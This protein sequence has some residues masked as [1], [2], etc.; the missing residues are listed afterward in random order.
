MLKHAQWKLLAA[1]LS[2]FVIAI[3]LPANADAAGIEWTTTIEEQF[4]KTTKAA[5]SKTA[6]SLTSASSSFKKLLAQDDR[7]TGDIK[8]L[9][10]HNEE[11]LLA[12]KK[13]IKE[14]NANKLAQLDQQVQ[15]TRR[16]YQPLL[17]SYTA[18]NKQITA[19]KSLK[20]KTLTSYLQVQAKVLKPLT[21][22]ARE[23]IK[24]KEA[25]LKALKADTTKQ[26]KIIRDTLSRID[27]VKVQIRAQRS[28]MSQIRKSLSPNW[29]N[30]KAAAKKSDP[31]SALTSLNALISLAKQIE[32]QQLRIHTLEK[33]ISTV[34]AKAKS[35]IPK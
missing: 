28:A 31:R 19:A 2:L 16:K 20:N 21:Q 1:V 7:L 6:A 3:L 23:D 14:I 26:A 13:Q 18:V 11:Q 27:T 8:S 33:E 17:D 30:F 29:S 15:N 24:A 9:Q 22:L 10:Y 25:A 12:I 4:A 35:Q 34:L 5:D 32:T